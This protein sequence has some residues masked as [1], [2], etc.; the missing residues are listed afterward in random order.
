LTQHNATDLTEYLIDQQPGLAVVLRQKIGSQNTHYVHG[1]R[2]IQSQVANSVWHDAVS[3]GL[4]SVRGWL[5]GA[6]DF[7][8]TMSYNPYGVP[9]GAVDGFGFIGEMTDENGLVYLRA[10]HYAPSIGN[11]V[12]LDPFEGFSNKPMS[13]NGYAYVEANPINWVDP[14]GM[15]TYDIWV[16]AFIAPP[17]LRFPFFGIVESE[18]DPITA[19]RSPQHLYLPSSVSVLDPV[20]IWEGDNR[21]WFTRFDSIDNPPSSRVWWSIRLDTEDL[22]KTQT[23]V[24]VGPTWVAFATFG[25]GVHTLTGRATTP[26]NPHIECIDS[27]M[28]EIIISISAYAQNPLILSPSIEVNHQIRITGQR[29]NDISSSYWGSITVD[30]VIDAYPW[31]EVYILRTDG[32]NPSPQIIIRQEPAS[33]GMHPMILGVPAYSL[34]QNTLHFKRVIINCNLSETNKIRPEDINKC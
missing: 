3:D 13:I 25:Q 23:N 7:V 31:H 4:G 27:S 21:S 5:D 24:G 9:D 28:P 11:F 15:A 22:S 33:L 17:I 20:A 1:L 34:S 10:R 19:L 12:S 29:Q 16:A 26:D 8:D 32:E 30:S 6:G 18:F 14:S 2:G